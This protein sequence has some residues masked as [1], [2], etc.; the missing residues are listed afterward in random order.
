[1]PGLGIGWLDGIQNGKTH[2]HLQ[3]R[4]KE[5]GLKLEVSDTANK[6]LA[7]LGY[8]PAYGARPLKRTIQREMMDSLALK[9]LEGELQEGNT[10][11]VDTIDSTFLFTK[12]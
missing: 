1:L 7:N 2:H 8:D 3:R 5:R 6:L 9:I 11:L 12:Q 10:I 4:L